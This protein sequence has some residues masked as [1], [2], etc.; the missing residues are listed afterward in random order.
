MRDKWDRP[1]NYMRISVTNRCN[2]RCQY[3]MPAEGVPLPKDYEELTVS[4]L[5]LIAKAAAELGIDRIKITGGEPLVRKDIGEL[6]GRLKAVEGIQQVTLT[7]NGVLLSEYS[8]EFASSAP[9]CININLPSFDPLI[10]QRVTRRDELLRVKASL[11]TALQAGLKI[12]INCVGREDLSKGELIDFLAF[13][14]ENPVD[15]RFIEMMPIGLGKQQNVRT[16][17]QIMLDLESASGQ[18]L[19]PTTWKGNG[20]AVYYELAGHQGKIGFISAISH[21]FCETCNRVRITADG[22]LKL[23][24]DYEKGVSIKQFAKDNDLEALTYAMHAAI[25]EKPQAHSF[26]EL[27]NEQKEQRSMVEI[28]G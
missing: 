11:D 7:T 23:C 10:Y 28:G 27:S 15:V 5:E 25:Y 4:E 8:K 12:K 24:L 6:I 19:V 14:K 22:D 1:I 18:K 3:C 20:P 9:D 13:V 16:N 21:K 17:D 2:L 26:H